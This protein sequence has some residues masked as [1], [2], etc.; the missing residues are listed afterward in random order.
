MVV[1]IF[2]FYPFVPPFLH[3]FMNVWPPIQ[4]FYR[5]TADIT[6]P[7]ISWMVSIYPVS[8][9]AFRPFKLLIC[10]S[11]HYPPFHL[12]FMYVRPTYASKGGSVPSPTRHKLLRSLNA[13]NVA[14]LFPDVP[15]YSCRLGS[16][17][18]GGGGPVW[19]SLFIKHDLLT[20]HLLYCRA[21]QP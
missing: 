12:S 10:Q 18:D 21:P 17:Y 7:N 5:W 16:A 11:K 8:S 4:S 15:K 3:S 19:M 2:S 13:S 1:V 9:S 20:P 6:P 14:L